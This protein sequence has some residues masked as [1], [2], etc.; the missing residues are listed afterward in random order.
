MRLRHLSLPLRTTLQETKSKDWSIWNSPVSQTCSDE[1]N[2]L[3][4]VKCHLT[5]ARMEQY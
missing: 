1:R 5:T 4:A 2:Y 3:H